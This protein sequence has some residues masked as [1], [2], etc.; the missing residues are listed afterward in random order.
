MNDYKGPKITNPKYINYITEAT[1]QFTIIETPEYLADLSGD[2]VYYKVSNREYV[3]GKY[4]YDHCTDKGYKWFQIFPLIG[5]PEA[6]I[7]YVKEK[8]NIIPQDLNGFMFDFD[9]DI[10][11]PVNG[12]RESKKIY[13]VSGTIIKNKMKSFK[14]RPIVSKSMEEKIKAVM[15]EK[16]Y[17]ESI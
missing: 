3:Y 16:H 11:F 4:I 10:F 2:R 8:D 12:I 1:F 14:I 13:N 6:G 9:M 7:T 5:K 15:L 17:K